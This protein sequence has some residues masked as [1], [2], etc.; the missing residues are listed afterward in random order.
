MDDRPTFRV[1]EDPQERDPNAICVTLFNEESE[2]MAWFIG[3]V[4]ISKRGVSI[5]YLPRSERRPFGWALIMAMGRAMVDR[6]NICV[7]DPERLWT[8]L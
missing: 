4:A 8:T 3:P 7:V 2:L 6:C 1:I 5:A